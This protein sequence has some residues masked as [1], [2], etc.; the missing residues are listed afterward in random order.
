MGGNWEFVRRHPDG[1]VFDERY[2]QNGKIH[3]IS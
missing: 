1:L 3:F 2:K